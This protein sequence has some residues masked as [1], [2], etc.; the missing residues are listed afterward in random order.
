MVSVLH[1]FLNQLELLHAVR[2]HPSVAMA[3]LET[4]AEL[5]GRAVEALLR[6][7]QQHQTLLISH[8]NQLTG[9]AVGINWLRQADLGL[10]ETMVAV[11]AYIDSESNKRVALEAR[12][13]VLEAELAKLK[14][15]KQT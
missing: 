13:A 8:D 3:D 14:R 6:G 9:I 2:I 1:A 11:A 7:T 15:D 12:V 10:A 4:K 5:I